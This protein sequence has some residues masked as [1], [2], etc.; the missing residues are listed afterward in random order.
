MCLSCTLLAEYASTSSGLQCWQHRLVGGILFRSKTVHVIS[1]GDDVDLGP[2][3]L[4][5]VLSSDE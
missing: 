5:P 4:G 2:L 1:K 3:E